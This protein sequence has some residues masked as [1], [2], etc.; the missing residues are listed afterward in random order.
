MRC[1]DLLG[2]VKGEAPG[3]SWEMSLAETEQANGAEGTS[4]SLITVLRAQFLHH[5]IKSQIWKGREIFLCLFF[6]ALF[7][8]HFSNRLQICLKGNFSKTC[9]EWIWES[10]HIKQ[11]GSSACSDIAE[12]ANRRRKDRW[13]SSCLPL[14]TFKSYIQV[15]PLAATLQIPVFLK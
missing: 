12:N 8:P 15:L 7:S 9:L 13:S 3:G 11:E 4:T 10:E 2:R 1:S 6:P 14:H 5:S